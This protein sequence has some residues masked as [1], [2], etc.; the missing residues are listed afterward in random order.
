LFW[1]VFPG[2]DFGGNLA[3]APE[4]AAGTGVLVLMPA[5]AALWTCA[6]FILSFLLAV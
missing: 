2:V 3:L 4:R 1:I 6:A 5:A